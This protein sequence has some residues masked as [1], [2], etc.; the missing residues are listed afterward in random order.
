MPN[1]EQTII[2]LPCYSLEDFQVSRN[3]DESEEILAGWCGL[4]HPVLLHRTQML[5]RWER[6]YDPPL[7]PD[8]ALIIIP[9]CSE[10]NLPSTWLADLP[11][12]QV[13][14]IQRSARP[15]ASH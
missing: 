6:A 9:E 2:L 10:K 12:D 5:P 4:F 13:T 7:A 15:V 3:D 11:A 8:Q 1:I 14:V